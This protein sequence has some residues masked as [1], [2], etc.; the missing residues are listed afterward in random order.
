MAL[1]PEELHY[2]GLYALTAMAD[3]L[4]EIEARADNYALPIA[5]LESLDE[6]LE[7]I[8]QEIV[9]VLDDMERR[10]LQWLPQAA[11]EVE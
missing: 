10:D 8:E 4:S 7:D 3:L 5:F 6:L 1:L 11:P 9:T 2:Y